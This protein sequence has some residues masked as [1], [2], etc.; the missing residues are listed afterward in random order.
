ME[1]FGGIEGGGT[2]FVCGVGSSP[3]D[4]EVAEFPT[5]N[6]PQETLAPV[7]AFLREKGA[8]QSLRAVGIASF[9]P[10]DLRAG[11]STF[12]YITTTPKPGWAHFNFAGAVRVA[13]GVEVAFETDTNGAAFGEY[14]WGA[15]QGLD[16]SVYLTVGTGIGGGIVAGG[17]LIHGMVHPEM[18][19]I[20]VPHDWQA[21]PFPGVCP[22][23]GDCL[24]GLASGP[25]M[26]Q[27]WN[28]R[29]RDL[30][31]GHPAWELE[32]EYLALAVVNFVCTVSPQRVILGGG[33]MSQ[34]SLFPRIRERLAQLLN[35]YIQAPEVTEHL[36]TYI[37]PPGLGN[38]SGVLGAIALAQGCYQGLQD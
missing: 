29:G 26:E 4:L 37:V 17:R 8:R 2:K 23:H 27:R 33:V 18:G 12:G 21:D 20:R 19:H 31:P 14:T 38:R 25:A 13:L 1:C 10:V 16:T 22:Y 7:I 36:D 15:S 32:A 35:G 6:S 5:T 30:A 24:E 11:S 9:G 28:T 34:K 3:S